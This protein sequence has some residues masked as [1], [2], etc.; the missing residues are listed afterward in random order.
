MTRYDWSLI[1]V[2]PD[3][4]VGE[5][6]NV[7]V[8]VGRPDGG[9]WIVRYVDDET[10]A[11]QLATPQHLATVREWVERVRA[12]ADAGGLSRDRLD[13]MHHDHRNL[14]QLSPP[15]RMIAA[16]LDEAAGLLMAELVVQTRR[17]GEAAS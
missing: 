1:R 9:E 17:V 2:V 10:H 6:V 12:E 4:F 5:F 16:R 7:G 13:E 14:V 3:S 15:S 8:M 11:L